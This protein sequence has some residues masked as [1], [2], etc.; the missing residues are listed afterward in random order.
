MESFPVEPRRRRFVEN[1]I[2]GIDIAVYLIVFIAGLYALFL[3]PTSVTESLEGWKWL[4]PWWAAFLLVGGLFG[5][6]GRISTIWMFEPP[7]DF[8]AFIGIL[9]YF[10]V[11]GDG[12][13]QSLASGVSACFVFAAL[14]GVV[15]R[16]LEL[17]LFGSDPAHQDLKSKLEDT[18]NRRIPNVPHRG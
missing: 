12:I 8:A 13:F 1:S 7:A 5:M 11:L 2:R 6:I 18:W 16:Y 17:Q 9:I 15:R 10:I 14:L 4:I 3:T